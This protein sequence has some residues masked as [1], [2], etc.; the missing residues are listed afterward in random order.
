MVSKEKVGFIMDYLKFLTQVID[1]GIRAAKA[2]YKKPKDKLR[3][4]GSI[5]GFESCRDKNP[6]ELVDLYISAGKDMNQA[7][8]DS[9]YGKISIDEYW[10]ISCRHAEIEWV[11][12]VVSSMLMNQGLPTIIAPTARGFI[13]AAE[14]LGVAHKVNLSFD[15]VK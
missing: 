13:K 15:L 3:L 7:Y 4:K 11:C 9:H 5:E 10:R 1:D 2:D 8:D 14:I 12:N 6:D